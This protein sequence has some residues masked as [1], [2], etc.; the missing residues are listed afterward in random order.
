M[1]TDF[2]S[3]ASPEENKADARLLTALWRMAGSGRSNNKQAL[4]EIRC[5]GVPVHYY[6]SFGQ[7]NFS[8]T[9]SGIGFLC[10]PCLQCLIFIYVF[11]IR[12]LH[13][14]LLE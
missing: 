1:V 12:R 10:V 8:Y 5:K 4:R 9:C 13:M 7:R 14:L 11:L 6:Q 3:T 2:E